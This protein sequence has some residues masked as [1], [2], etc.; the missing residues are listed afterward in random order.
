MTV[1]VCIP[2]FNQ[3]PF[4]E[5]AIWSA[6][7]QSIKPI[8]IIVSDDASTDYT[9]SILERLR[10]EI[11]ILKVITQTVNHGIVFNV[12]ACLKAAKGDLIVRLDSDD[13]LHPKYVESF[14]PYFRENINIG[15][16]HCATFEIDIQGIVTRLRTLYRKE[17][18]QNS[19]IALKESLEGYK[20]TA[21]I[22]IFRRTTLEEVGF[23][24]S[25]VN[26]AEDYYLACSISDSGYSNVYL[27]NK[28]ASYRVWNDNKKIRNKRKLSEIVGLNVVFSEVIEP[29][30]LKRGWSLKNVTR[31]KERQAIRH[32]DCL[33]LDLYSL[34]E[35]KELKAE[36]LRLSNTFKAKMVYYSYLHGFGGVINLNKWFLSKIKNLVKSL[37]SIC[38][39]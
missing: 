35:K 7:N 2:T 15:F 33:S 19:T 18:V 24:Q 13:I 16:G 29:A 14:L 11:P 37:I 32:S 5:D 10:N 21:N 30:F 17:N 6:Y 8:E 1:S 38:S 34:S 20:V 27:S 31:A 39:N 22:L 36:L 4:I 3:A 9:N 26:F 28:L 12:N 23:I 25:K